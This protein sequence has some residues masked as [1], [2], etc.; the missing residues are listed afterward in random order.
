MIIRTRDPHI[1]IA[2]E[3]I[4]EHSTEKA[5]ALW[6][7]EMRGNGSKMLK[8][9][10]KSLAKDNGNGTWGMPEWVAFDRGLI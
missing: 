8:F 5:F 1:E 4:T 9:V 6:D 10:P 3:E 2:A 7:G